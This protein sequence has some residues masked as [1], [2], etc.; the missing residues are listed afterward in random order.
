MVF[1]FN[2]SWF[3]WPSSLS[4]KYCTRLFLWCLFCYI[5]CWPVWWYVWI[6]I[7]IA[8]VSGDSSTLS[9]SHSQQFYLIILVCMHTQEFSKFSV[10]WPVEQQQVFWGPFIICCTSCS[11]NTILQMWLFLACSDMFI[12]NLWRR[13]PLVFHKLNNK[14][15]FSNTV[16]FFL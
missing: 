10:L 8:T 14:G 11:S 3:S 16:V 9:I 2:P 12:Y 13:H 7:S 15:N 1:N 6:V 5:S 4:S